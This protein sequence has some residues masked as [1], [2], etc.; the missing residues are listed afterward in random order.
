MAHTIFDCCGRT[1]AFRY[2]EFRVNDPVTSLEKVI[3]DIHRR[4]LD[5]KS[6]SASIPM[7]LDDMW[8][9]NYFKNTPT[10]FEAE[11]ELESK[12]TNLLKKRR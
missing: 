12:L 2:N 7:S 5:T 11:V 6:T 8:K 1:A 9:V 4:L 10:G 3:N